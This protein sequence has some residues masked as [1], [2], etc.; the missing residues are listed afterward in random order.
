MAVRELLLK[1]QPHFYM[2]SDE[3]SELMPRWDIC[4]Y[5]PGDYGEK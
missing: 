5:T 3:I 4:I 2:Y 1:K